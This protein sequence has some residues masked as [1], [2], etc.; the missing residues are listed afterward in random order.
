MKK[1]LILSLSIILMA[2]SGFAQKTLTGTVVDEAGLP[3]PGATVVEQGTTNGTTTD[4]DGNF[5]ISVADGSILEVSYIGYTSIE[6][7]SSSDNLTIILLAGNELDEIVI[8]GYTT[9]TKRTLTDNIATVNSDDI[10]GVPTPNLI[11]TL[12]GK[13]AGVQ[14]SQTN[15]KVE[16][17][18]QFRIRGQSSVSAGTQPLYVLDG[19]PLIV[20]NES[21]NGAPTNPLI[22]L[23]P[24]EIE[25]IDILKDA[26]AASIYGSRGANGVVLITTKQGKEGKAKFNVSVSNG[27]SSKSNSRDWMN[28]AE[29]VE[30][31]TEA[32]QNG[33]DYGGWPGNGA[34]YATG[35]FDRYS[36]GTWQAGT[37]DTNWE[38]IALVDGYTRDANISMSGGNGKTSY[39]YSLSNNDTKGIVRGNELNKIS[40]RVNVSHKLTK[41]FKVGMNIGFNRTEIDRVSNDNSFT[42]PLQAIAQSPI[43]PAFIGDEPYAGTVYVNFLLQ[44]K[45]GSYKTIIR[46][47]TGKFYGDLTILPNLTFTSSLAYDLFTQSEDQFNGSLTP[48]Q[49]TNGEAYGSNATTENYI[50]TNLINY[51][52]DFGQDHNMTLTIGTELNKSKRRFTSVTG[53]QFPTDDFQ[54]VSSA[55]EVTAGSGTF[56]A[57]SFVSYFSR[58][59]YSYKDRYLFKAG[60]R[61]DGSSRFGTDVRFGTFPSASAGWILSEEDFLRDNSL[62]SFLKLRGSWGE[63]G[64]AEIGN[65]ASRGL[66]GGVSYNQRPGIAPTQAENASLSWETSSQIDIS[67]QFGLLDDRISGELTYY[68]K[69]TDNLLFD[70]PIP[71]SSG[72]SSLT[73]NIGAVKNSGFEFIISTKNIV[74]QDFSWNTDFNFGKNENK[75]V[76]LPNGEDSVSGR[77]I[78]RVGS[79]INSFYLLEYAGVDPANGDALYFT[80]T[81]TNGVF[82][83]TTTNDTGEAERRVM[84]NPFPEILVGLSNTVTYKNFDLNIIFQGEW[85]ASIYNGGGRFQSA[86]GDWFDNQTR[87]QLARWQKPGDITNIPQARLGWSN[88]TGHSSRYLEE[89]D[90][91]RLRNVTL[92]YNFQQSTISKLGLSDARLYVSGLNLLTITDYTGYDP[93]SRSDAGGVGQVF[94]SAPA[95]S[96][97]SVGL[98]ISF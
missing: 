24:A 13:V 35:R 84:G 25:S 83:K 52:K 20:N 86:N 34:A 56:T 29:Y 63:V 16:S 62:I 70:E 61:R 90:F 28:A 11:N 67:A 9:Q 7:N 4:F 88:G 43:S 69:D 22:T 57:Y 47:N 10:A 96:T 74:N 85:G 23:N 98:N 64:N 40:A 3:L 97:M 76:S 38:D 8:T 95:A 91:I 18:F 46:R 68:V 19:I 65:F 50:V 30:I 77:N 31:F 60:L 51:T 27:F 80:N 73:K 12:A 41:N 78:L 39:F 89:A 37:Y 15:C 53:Q 79:P 87:D 26:S 2:F 45:Y 48:F 32:A 75:V 58:A 59:T 44:D 42:T 49:S 36:D 14:I 33:F 66:F 21:N 82:S 72:A 71:T 94:Y 81:E 17:G 92:G 93:E 6:V 1:N 55:A 5:T 54:T